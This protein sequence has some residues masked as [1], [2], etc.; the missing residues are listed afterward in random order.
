MIL[1]G[2]LLLVPLL[3]C[4]SGRSV[5]AEDQEAKN[6]AAHSSRDLPA[7]NPPRDSTKIATFSI[8]AVDPETGVVGAAVASKYPAVGKVVLLVA[9]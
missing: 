7:R 4:V 5:M 9:P 2:L 6:N 1:R 3:C 8:V